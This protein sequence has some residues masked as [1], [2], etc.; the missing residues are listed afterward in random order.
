N[1]DPKQDSIVRTEATRL[2][3]R[4][5]E[6]YLGKGRNDAL[7]IELPKGGY[8]PV[9]R[10]PAVEPPMTRAGSEVTSQTSRLRG[11]PECADSGTGTRKHVAWK[12]RHRMAAVMVVVVGLGALAMVRSLRKSSLPAPG[13]SIAVLPF[14]DLSPTRDQEYFS[15]G[16]TDELISELSRID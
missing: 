1:H 9:F 5:G 12:N 6:Y 13:K 3:A 14:L 16:M 15:D 10:Q 11:L 4:L 7:V 2:R 8:S